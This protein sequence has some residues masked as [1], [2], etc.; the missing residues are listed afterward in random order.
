MGT[1]TVQGAG[2]KFVSSL[3]TFRAIF[4]FPRHLTNTC[5]RH[6]P[7]NSGVFTL[8]G[9]SN[10]HWYVPDYF[11]VLLMLTRDVDYISRTKHPKPIR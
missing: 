1:V 9:L 8:A 3:I 11:H 5:H 7:P 10:I 2:L 6:N 4:C